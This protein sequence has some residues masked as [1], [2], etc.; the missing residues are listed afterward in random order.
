MSKKMIYILNEA[1]CVNNFSYSSMIAAQNLGF[2]YHIAGNWSYK[3]DNERIAD[4]KK[5][6]I[7][8]HQI[9][10]IRKPYHPSNLKAYKQLVKIVEK[11]R[12]DV[13][14]CNTPIGG[15]AGRLLGKRFKSSTVI[16][17][18]HGFHFYKGAPIV[19]WMLFYPVEKWL[20]HYTDVLITINSED[21]ELAQKK[22]KLR[23]GGRVYYAHGVGIDLSQ[24]ELP[25][26]TRKQK[27][28]ELDL[29]ETDI[30]LISMGDLIERKN[31][32][33]AINAVA[34]A[35]NASLQYFICGDGPEK[36]KLKKIAKDLGVIDQIHFLGYR[37]DVKELLKAADIFLFTSKQEGLARSLMEAMANGLPCI[38]SRIRGNIDLLSG[39]QDSFLCETNN[40]ESYAEKINVLAKNPKMREKIG[41]SSLIKVH[42]YSM[43][44]V[45]NE[46]REYYIAS[47]RDKIV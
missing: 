32:S 47:I 42:N 22:M 35:G 37:T 34:K 27:R 41:R 2:E 5:Y 28:L 26:N 39:V 33:V 30:A 7:H 4:E 16:Y 15:I 23:K 21:F 6:G 19:N 17:Q 43:N 10:F 9:D 18:V 8:I 1:N 38:A 11:E 24:Y 45:I 31:Y 3:S 44:V 25:E 40:I 36:N 20:A 14:H 29:K 46:L 13:I 12:F